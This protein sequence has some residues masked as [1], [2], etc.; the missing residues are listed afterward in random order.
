MIITKKH[1]KK[2]LAELGCILLALLAVLYL[3][4]HIV[5]GY[6]R[7][8][9]SEA[10]VYLTEDLSIVSEGVIFRDESV[11]YSPSPDR[12]VYCGRDG[13]KLSIGE[14]AAIICASASNTETTERLRILNHRIALIEEALD[15]PSSITNYEILDAE[16]ITLLGSN[17]FG[18]S[19]D[20]VTDGARDA[21]SVSL[22][23]AAM[24]DS[25][26]RTVAALAK[27]KSERDTLISALSASETLAFDRPL[28]F[29]QNCDGGEEIFTT[30]ALDGLD[31][32]G[33]DRLIDQFSATLPQPTAIGK[34]TET[35]SWQ[36]AF[37]LSE[38]DA[39]RLSEGRSYEVKFT[40]SGERV[41]GRLESIAHSGERRL[42]VFRFTG[43]P[44]NFDYSRIQPISITY[45]SIEGYRVPASAVRYIEGRTCVYTI[46]G[47][48]IFLRTADI[49][50]RSGEWC[51]ISPDSPSLELENG[52]VCIGLKQNDFVVVR[53]RNLYHLKIVE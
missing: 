11:V 25:R 12:V 8:V 34:T 46:Y 17:H 42:A 13:E 44:V 45:G 47:G 48:Q 5:S 37:C 26:E 14:S 52:E 24:K 33:L 30:A 31:A 20:K 53:A 50:A 27:M 28:F 6:A 21:L 7:G 4:Y 41:K 43:M 38:A 19:S 29:Y 3:L 35:H 10:A 23:R 32:D 22:I 39:A 36:L 51:Y 16:I 9:D 40:L 2:A 49:A 15:A 18:G 1:L